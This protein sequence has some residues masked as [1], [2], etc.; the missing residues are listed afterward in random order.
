MKINKYSKI[1]SFVGFCLLTKLFLFIIESVK[2]KFMEDTKKINWK[3]E[4]NKYLNDVFDKFNLILAFS[5]I[6][7]PII[8][9]L[10]C[11]VGVQMDFK[12]WLL[13][14][15]VVFIIEKLMSVCLNLRFIKI[16]KPDVLEILAIVLFVMLCVAEFVNGPVN[17]QFI[18]ILGYFFVF[19][20][21]LKVD[22]KYYKALMYTFVLTMVVCS[23]MGVCDLNNSYMPGFGDYNYDVVYPM[24]LQF[25]N[26][27]Y[28]AYITIM[29][30]M[31]CIYIL[32]TYK[33]K[34]EQIIFWIAYVVLNVCLFIN[35]CF[36]AETAMFVGQLF[37]LI[38][39]W[40]KNKKCPWLIWICL[41]ISIAAS[42]VWIKGYST[43][44]ANYMFEAL[45]VIDNNLGTNLVLNIST[46]FDKLFGTGI[47]SDVAGSDGW[48]RAN[49]TERALGEIFA[50][51][52]SI[53]FGYGKGYNNEILVHNV[54]L[55]IWLESGGICLG[56]YLSILVILAIRMFKTKFSSHNIYVIAL[57]I[58]VVLVCHYFACLEPYSFTYFVCLLTVS[59][60]SLNEKHKQLKEN[61]GKEK[62]EEN[63]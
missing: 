17:A 9:S 26:P 52:K 15:Y 61:Q 6:L 51:P 2:G 21:F 13:I 57:M 55:Q 28:A 45:A 49:L 48:D 60:R 18:F 50:G 47:I 41:G 58:A 10:I 20:I 25:N 34:A 54:A 23:I 8:T 31:L 7:A 40:I 30:I 27:N 62:I 44:K 11:L 39:L 46:F 33:T 16:R 42:F 38:F 53:F 5:I 32:S 43:S 24:S 14:V 12:N 63:K 22:K 4:D 36:S 19:L 3:P 35:G 37:L 59:I 1:K 29:A 56:L